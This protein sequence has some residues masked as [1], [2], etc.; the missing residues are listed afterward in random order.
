M[1]TKYT[2]FVL[3]A[4]LLVLP[5]CNKWLD[6]SPVDEISKGDMYST[7]DGFYN[8][9]NG[10]YQDIGTTDL[11]GQNLTWGAM[12]AWGRGYTLDN[13][14]SAHETF[15]SLRDL[16]YTDDDV[17]SL[18]RTI[19]LGLYNNIAR[20]N[21]F[22]QSCQEK[23]DDFFRYGTMEKNLM[24][25]EALAIR[26]YLHF[27]LLRIF[28]QSLAEGAEGRDDAYIPYVTEYPSRVNPP[29]KS[30][31]V[32]SRIEEDLA[33]AAEYV[34][35]YDTLETNKQYVLSSSLRFSSA[36][37]P[38][39]GRFYSQRGCRLNYYAIRAVQARVALYAGEYE[40]AKVFAGEILDVVEEQ[41][42]Q[43]SLVTSSTIAD[44]PKMMGETLFGY[45]YDN[46]IDATQNWF[47]RANSQV[48]TVEDNANFSAISSDRRSN[49]ISNSVLTI[50]NEDKNGSETNYIPAV[51]LSELYYIMAEAQ[52]N[53]NAL[54]YAITLFNTFLRARGVTSSTYQIPSDADID[55]FYD[56]LY[57]D[58][59]KEY[60]G[61]G[62]NIFFFKRLNVP[63]RYSG[64]DM[65]TV[66]GQLVMPVP[67][68]ESAI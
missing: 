50:Y 28:G 26:A 54:S 9:L 23:P 49:L 8:V 33:Q 55:A 58:I 56:Y 39:W 44:S 34:G 36:N 25:G 4:L 38:E 64:G 15:I 66:V 57:D 40:N 48:L 3:S 13:Q 45:Y 47:D 42:S 62:Q 12:E 68:T 22:I 14:V 52:A 21:E 16:N 61:L 19:W 51:R 65:T 2:I 24:M 67:D 20:A 32:I 43:L 1:K 5:G 41:G 46:L 35:A 10:I 53:T 6:V 30:S 27:D 31:E 17:V 11:Y 7:T 63:I 37:T 29:L 59:R 60:A 18:G